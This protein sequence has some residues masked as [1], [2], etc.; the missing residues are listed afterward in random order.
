MPKFLRSPCPIVSTLDLVGDKW[1]LVVV[2]DMLTGKRHYSEFL[3]SPEGISTNILADRLRLLEREGIVR[4]KVY[5]RKPVRHEYLLTGKGRALLPA[6]QE[7]S[8]WGNRYISGTWVPPA[9][10]MQRK[11]GRP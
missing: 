9:W 11:P 8:R 3:E 10:F 6:L 2:R 4:R 5:Q 7:F 1:T